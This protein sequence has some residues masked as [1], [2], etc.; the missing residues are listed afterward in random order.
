MGYAP[1][2]QYFP[3]IAENETRSFSMYEKS[4]TEIPAGRYFLIESYCNEPGCDCRRVFLSVNPKGSDELP[5]VIAYGW[6]KN[7]Y[8]AKWYGENDSEVIKGLKGPTLNLSSPQ[9]GLAPEF[10]E[11]V[12]FILKD[13]QYVDRLKRHYELFREA[14]E[15]KEEKKKNSKKE[16]KTILGKVGRN[17]PC[18][19]GSGKKYKKCC[20]NQTS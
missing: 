9:S 11:V 12:K 17:A 19:C 6:E 10:L 13:K 5:A 2:H 15:N 16:S 8:Y 3:E 4:E 7:K 14:I 20:L 18:P 1:F